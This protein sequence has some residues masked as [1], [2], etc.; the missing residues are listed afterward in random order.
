MTSTPPPAG[1]TLK[2]RFT[3]LSISAERQPSKPRLNKSDCPTNPPLPEDYE[4]VRSLK[5]SSSEKLTEPF[6]SIIGAKSDA[7]L[8]LLRDE[9]SPIAAEKLLQ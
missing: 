8:K 3:E 9:V 6:D 7:V 5:Y 2:K 4:T 1:N